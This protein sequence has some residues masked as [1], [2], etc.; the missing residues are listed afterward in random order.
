VVAAIDT[1]LGDWF[2]AIRAG[3]RTPFLAATEVLAERIK[4][5]PCRVVGPQ[6]DVLAPQLGDAV[7]Q[8]TLPDAAISARL[9][10]AEGIEKW[11]ERN[12]REGLPRPLYLRGVNITLPDG[13]RRTVE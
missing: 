7:A 1:H 2:C 10:L 11:R 8:R 6:A 5:K 13:A 9:A 4:G 12:R 3:D